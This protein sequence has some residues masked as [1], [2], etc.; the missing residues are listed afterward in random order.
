MDNKLRELER[1]C[2]TLEGALEYIKELQRLCGISPMKKEVS[3]NNTLQRIIETKISELARAT[4]ITKETEEMTLVVATQLTD[5]GLNSIRVWAVSLGNY[6]LVNL[7]G[8]AQLVILGIEEAT[9]I[10][11]SLTEEQEH[12]VLTLLLSESEE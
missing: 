12:K 8:P 10:S 11:Y 5:A 7:D 9:S 1:N 2:T 3:K 4:R 6:C